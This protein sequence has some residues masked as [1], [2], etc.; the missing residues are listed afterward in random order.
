[1]K[2]VAFSVVLL[3][4]AFACSGSPEPEVVTPVKAALEEA[5]VIELSEDA[6]DAADDLVHTVPTGSFAD[7]A[8]FCAAQ[9]KLVAPKIA[10]ANA[11]YA[12]DGWGEMNLKPSCHELPNALEDA[13]VALVAPFTDVKAVM[14]ETG[15]STETYLLVQTSEGW[16]AVRAPLLYANHNDPGCGSI[17]RPGAILDVHTEKGALVIKTSAG[18]TWFNKKDEGG[19]LS[20]TYA[21][22]CRTG[23]TGI[24]CGTP[25]VIDAKVVLHGDESADAPVTTRFFSTSYEVGSGVAIEPATRFDEEQL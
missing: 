6:S 15:Y 20:L 4:S 19:D 9:T 13:T 3:V 2:R 22:A 11:S 16:T 21:R 18:R 7:V 14:F 24:A 5:P 1:M 8:A 25:E 17:E 23:P 12:T 10:E